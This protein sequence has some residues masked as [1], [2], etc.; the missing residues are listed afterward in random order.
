MTNGFEEMMDALLSHA[1]RQPMR[2]GWTTRTES[3]I[4]SLVP[5]GNLAQNSDRMSRLFMF[6]GLRLQ[7][8]QP[9]WLALHTRASFLDIMMAIKRMVNFLKKMDNQKAAPL[10]ALQAS[11]EIL[12]MEHVKSNIFQT[13][14]LQRRTLYRLV[15]TGLKKKLM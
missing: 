5:E 12:Y 8:L 11:W 6:R 9:H 1:S 4:V 2:E 7:V 15:Q 3:W 14:M 13:L 10:S